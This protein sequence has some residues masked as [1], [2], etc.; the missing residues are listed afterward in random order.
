MHV[1]GE[2]TGES[3]G[4]AIGEAGWLQRFVFVTWRLFDNSGRLTSTAV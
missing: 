4:E 2:A 3:M 1:P